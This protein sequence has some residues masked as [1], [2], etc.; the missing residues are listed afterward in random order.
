VL[1]FAAR[2][3]NAQI[4]PTSYTSA[5][6]DGPPPSAQMPLVAV[7]IDQEVDSPQAV[8][9]FRRPP[10]YQAECSTTLALLASAADSSE[11]GS[12][13]PATI[14]DKASRENN[15]QEE[16][17]SRREQHSQAPPPTQ[18]QSRPP[19]LEFQ[20]T[21]RL[22]NSS[23]EGND[24]EEEDDDE[25]YETPADESTT[26]AQIPVLNLTRHQQRFPPS[27]NQNLPNPPIPPPPYPGRPSVSGQQ[28]QQQKKAMNPATASL[29]ASL[30]LPPSVSAK[31]DKIIAGGTSSSTAGGVRKRPLLVGIVHRSAV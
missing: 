20:A 16:D 27:Q 11:Q 6:V 28:Q 5:S 3:R 15:S 17:A 14:E 4:P 10:E 7:S 23:K 18:S 8:P 29:I 19:P 24:V 1:I 31:V 13:T 12:A 21:V 30:Q 2:F 25:Q 9:D 26:E 22:E